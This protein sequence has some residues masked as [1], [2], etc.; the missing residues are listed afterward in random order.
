MARQSAFREDCPLVCTERSEQINSQQRDCRNHKKI[1][2]S[3]DET[4]STL[5]IVLFAIRNFLRVDDP[6][7]TG[8]FRAVRIMSQ[9]KVTH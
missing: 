5:A 9:D 7:R 1:A 4:A 2:E 3:E 8:V 6:I